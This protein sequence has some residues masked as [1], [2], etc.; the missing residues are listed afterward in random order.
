MKLIF[1]FAAAAA[2]DDG[3][4]NP[5]LPDNM[6]EL[7]FSALF[8]FALWAMLKYVLLP[9]ITA[10]RDARRAKAQASK[11]AAGNTEANLA[12][13]RAEHNEKLGVAKAEASR[14]VE[15]ARAEADAERATAV[16]AVEA[17]IAKLKTS[18]NADVDAARVSAMAG[19][20]GDVDNL[21]VAA[22]SKVLGKQ[23]DVGAQRSILDQVLGG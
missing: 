6:G 19:A 9:P 16:S 10:G 18:A 4:P 11:D 22:A 23:L 12:S 20:R 21:A 15:A 8:F 7:F 17:E 5:V 2:N 1:T 3:P 13:I 14:I